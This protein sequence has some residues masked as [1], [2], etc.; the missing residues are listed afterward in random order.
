[1][2]APSDID[3]RSHSGVVNVPFLPGD[4]PL[5]AAEVLRT[6]QIALTSYLRDT[7]RW[8]QSAFGARE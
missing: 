6:V 3:T 5:G 4:L 8:M 2:E 7:M 1:M